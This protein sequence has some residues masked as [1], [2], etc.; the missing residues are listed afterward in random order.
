M[1]P[2]SGNKPPGVPVV[3]FVACLL[4]LALAGCSSEEQAG[5][6]QA[7]GF[8]SG[9]SELRIE[10]TLAPTLNQDIN[11]LSAEAQVPGRV[12]PREV[13]LV[14]ENRGQSTRKLLVSGQ[15]QTDGGQ[16]R[17]GM[18]QVM[19]I[20]PGATGNFNAGT[21]SGLASRFVVTV[22]PSEM[23]E[24]QLQDAALVAA[25]NSG[26]PGHG[27][28]YTPTPTLAEIP[29]WTPRGVANGEAFRAQTVMIMPL[30]SGWKMEIH[31]REVDP[32]KGV[33]MTRS[34]Y[35]DVQT[36]YINLPA[37]PYKGAV[38][39][40]EM[41]YGGGHFQ[42]KSPSG[43]GTTSWNTSTAWV[44]EFTDWQVRPWQEGG[45]TF[46]QA[47]TASGRIYICYQGS[48]ENIRSS[49]VAGEFKNTPVMY[50]GAPP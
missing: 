19:D 30:E 18:N 21:R 26:V 48:P 2:S 40:R 3:N 29:A 20:E 5:S 15:W 16:G 22:E 17:G 41:A 39:E 14:L 35:P 38:F 4:L 6:D 43:S 24:E 10:V 31:D 8:V 23:T 45:D 34:V 47:G 1:D 9:S 37:E 46:Q 50:Y 33:A 32:L 11:I 25:A 44:I 36:L 12:N 42:I 13:S 28:A 49:F 27:V 7:P